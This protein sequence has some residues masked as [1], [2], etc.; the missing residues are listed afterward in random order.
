[1]QY[2]IT[3]EHLAI[4]AY[5]R[6]QGLEHGTVK[7]VG[8]MI[9]LEDGVL[10]ACP[11]GLIGEDGL[12]EIK[13]PYSIRNFKPEEWPSLAPGNSSLTLKSGSL[14]L[15]KSHNHYYQVVMQIYVT[16]RDW[17][18]YV[19]W[20]PNGIYVER[21]FRDENTLGVWVELREKLLKF[22]EEDLAVELV[23]SRERRKSKEFLCSD[24][25]KIGRDRN[26]ARN[27]KTANAN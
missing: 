12:L 17:G 20:T 1:M 2:G 15:K 27:A 7:K 24:E 4:A 21:I 13:C 25:R 26:L 11:D 14:Q 5:E 8:L 10:G 23:D 9:S 22:W 6:H 3:S 19:V 18:D 16:G